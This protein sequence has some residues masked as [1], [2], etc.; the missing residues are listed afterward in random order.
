MQTQQC[1]PEDL[2]SR[3]HWRLGLSGGD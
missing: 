1:A 3:P 2:K